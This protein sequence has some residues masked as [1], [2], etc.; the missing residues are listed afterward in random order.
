[1][2]KILINDSTEHGIRK[3]ELKLYYTIYEIYYVIKFDIK[4]TPTVSIHWPNIF[5]SIKYFI[6]FI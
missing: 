4:K 5:I 3:L 6:Y 2:L 1:M